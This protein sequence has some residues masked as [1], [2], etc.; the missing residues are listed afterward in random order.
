MNSANPATN[1][2]LAGLRFAVVALLLMAA[3]QARADGSLEYAVK[4][5]YLYKF[6]PFVEWPATAFA[7][8]DSPI[9][10][11]VSG[12][13]PFGALLDRATADQRVDGRPIAVHHIASVTADSGCHILFIGDSVSQA[14]DAV[15][16]QPVL[17]V[18]DDAP[19]SHGIINF[20]IR[21]GKV[22]FEIDSDAAAQNH[23]VISSKLLNLGYRP[24][25]AN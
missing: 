1:R 2:L 20:V 15:R 13:D 8:A 11:C 6:A 18:T 24:G 7:S 14:L 25:Q 3:A 5:T 23:L 17:T 22:R 16:G 4:A 21:D 12:T 10:I 19:G 9:T